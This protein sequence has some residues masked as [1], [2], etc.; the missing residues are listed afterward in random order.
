[1]MRPQSDSQDV[2]GGVGLAGPA[3]GPGSGSSEKR[4]SFEIAKVRQRKEG[5]EEE[6]RQEA[7]PVPAAATASGESAGDLE[8][9]L[10]GE[11]IF[12][13]NFVSLKE[14]AGV[15]MLVEILGL[16]ITDSADTIQELEELVE[17]SNNRNEAASA[18]SSSLE[19]S[20]YERVR[21]LVHRLKGSC[22][23][24]GTAV[25]CVVCEEIREACVKHEGQETK[26]AIG[27]LRSVFDSA[28]KDLE[29]Y[30]SH[31]EKPSSPSKKKKTDN[32]L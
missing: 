30:L 2:G 31:F 9:R 8:A 15:E 29:K 24:I 26:T 3:P 18:P 14:D 7:V 19:E 22:L 13:E 11:G 16:Y 23:N 21:Y 12:D 10:I 27:K 5:G 20:E 6:E 28:R 32:S 17:K 25:L 4:K 1:M